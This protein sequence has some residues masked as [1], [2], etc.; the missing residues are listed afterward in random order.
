VSDL[1]ARTVAS[2]VASWERYAG[3][4][5]GAHVLRDDDAAVAV[6]PEG[7]ER[8]VLNNAVVLGDG[9]RALA[10]IAE[11][12]SAAGID[13][14]AVWVHESR[15]DAAQVLERAGHHVVERTMA[16]V[17]RLPVAAP[18]RLATAP[19]SAGT[20]AQLRAINELPAQFAPGMRPDGS[21]RILVAGEP[22]QAALLALDHEEDCTLA[23]MSTVPTARRHG[24]ATALCARAL[25]DAAARGCTT[26]SLQSTPEAEGVY[27]AV[28]FEAIG[29]F[30][31][32]AP[33]T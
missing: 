24:L 3:W 20:P 28:G 11:A 18:A 21:A 6:F 29:R 19:I 14:Y 25:A 15:A 23:W 8:D 9:E 30:R 31:E 22:P 27:R 2:L 16:M 10:V 12:Y 5:P 7:S 17:A 32:Y 13:R 26:A 33:R 4:T 1:L